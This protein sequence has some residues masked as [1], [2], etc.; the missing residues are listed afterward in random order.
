MAGLAARDG[1]T[2]KE[3]CMIKREKK[4][5]EVNRIFLLL[6]KEAFFQKAQ[7]ISKVTIV[8]SALFLVS[9]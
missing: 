9:Y 6:H 7:V 4:V 8:F 1:V 3:V 5:L 2:G